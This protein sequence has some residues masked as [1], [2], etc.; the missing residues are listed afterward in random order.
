M[1]IGQ[2]LDG[3]RDTSA[4]SAEAEEEAKTADKLA[5]FVASELYSLKA[6]M[7]ELKS[8]VG[9]LGNGRVSAE[10]FGMQAAVNELECK[11]S[12][13][14]SLDKEVSSLKTSVNEVKSEV[15]GLGC[16]TSGLEGLEEEIEGLGEC[17]T[18]Q[19]QHIDH[20][21]RMELETLSD[22]Q[23][24]ILKEL[25]SHNDTTDVIKSIESGISKIEKS[26]GRQIDSLSTLS[27]RIE[28]I[29][30]SA[31][32]GSLCGRQ[33]ES[34]GQNSALSTDN[35]RNEGA[36]KVEKKVADPVVEG[37]GEQGSFANQAT[38]NGNRMP[39]EVRCHFCLQKLHPFASLS[40]TLI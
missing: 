38:D 20:S 9:S 19:M 17:L 3:A 33:D 5:A 29:E 37:S 26:V 23:K 40:V 39:T 4:E 11:V 35:A 21:L 1:N 30:T 14:H 6:V 15:Q 10:I 16:L 22:W 34:A 25:G 28:V 18:Y 12:S 2:P 24:Q 13:L 27:E 8:E 36:E 31:T 7:E 32:G